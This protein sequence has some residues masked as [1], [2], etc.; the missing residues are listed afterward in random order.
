MALFT[1]MMLIS[2]LQETKSI[3]VIIFGQTER[4]EKLHILRLVRYFTF[5]APK[6]L[7]KTEDILQQ[8]I[9]N[10]ECTAVVG[11]V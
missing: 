4:N 11:T 7:L 10:E 3:V 6:D 5:I 9:C 1:R 8:A 2:R